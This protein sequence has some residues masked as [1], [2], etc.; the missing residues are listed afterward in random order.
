MPITLQQSR[1][2][3][4]ELFQQMQNEKVSEKYYSI[5]QSVDIIIDICMYEAVIPRENMTKE[6]MVKYKD[7]MRRLFKVLTSKSKFVQIRMPTTANV[8]DSNIEVEDFIRRMEEAYNIDYTL[9]KE[10]CLREKEKIQDK[11]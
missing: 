6:G 7:Y 10:M 8:Q 9:L 3:N 1:N 2:F 4:A 11:K 5:F